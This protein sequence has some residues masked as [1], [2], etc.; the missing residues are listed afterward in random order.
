MP[1]LTGFSQVPRLLELYGD[2]AI[3]D[4]EGTWR[5]LAVAAVK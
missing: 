5:L 2:D 4:D 1:A 3:K